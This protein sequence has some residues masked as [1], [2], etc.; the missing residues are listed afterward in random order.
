MHLSLY[1]GVAESLFRSKDA[2]IT[3][4]NAAVMGKDNRVVVVDYTSHEMTANGIGKT[5]AVVLGDGRSAE[6]LLRRTC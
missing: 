2:S 1:D 5:T 3:N 6:S 4:F